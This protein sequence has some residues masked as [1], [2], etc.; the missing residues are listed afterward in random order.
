VLKAAGD[1]R[2]TGTGYDWL[3][4]PARMPPKERKE[5]AQLR[6]SGFKTARAWDLEGDRHGAVLLCL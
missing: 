6:N 2:L 4:Q 3:R 5:F 1:D